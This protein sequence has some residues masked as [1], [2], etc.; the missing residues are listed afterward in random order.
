MATQ[1]T[2]TETPT[3]AALAGVR[4]DFERKRS[5]SYMAYAAKREALRAAYRG[6]VMGG[7]VSAKVAER[8]LEALQEGED[9]AMAEYRERGASLVAEYDAARV[10]AG[11]SPL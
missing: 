1:Y 8:A 6:A 9:A 11:F 2:M 10:A 3:P 7:K 5:E 4:A